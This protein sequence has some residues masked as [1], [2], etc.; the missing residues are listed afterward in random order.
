MNYVE[1][2]ALFTPD[3]LADGEVKSIEVVVTGGNYVRGSVL[4]KI[5]SSGNYTLSASAAGNGSE[6]PSMVLA[7]DVDATSNPK[8][9]AAIAAG[10]VNEDEL[11][12]GTGHTADSVRAPLR[13]V[14][15]VLTKSVG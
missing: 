9:A 12:F 7:E 6:T 11:I 5:T 13:D 4:G 8:R 1:D 14:G 15:I 2:H 10:C 3:Q